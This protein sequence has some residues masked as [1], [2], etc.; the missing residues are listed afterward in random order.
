M[1]LAGERTKPRECAVSAQL[2]AVRD[3]A[4]ATV[5]SVVATIL[6]R[7]VP[8]VPRWRQVYPGVPSEIGYV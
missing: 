3:F 8:M 1:P 7:M 4:S 5:R 2:M 6:S